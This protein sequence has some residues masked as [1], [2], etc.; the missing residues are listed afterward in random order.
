MAVLETNYS[1]AIKEVESIRPEQTE[2][3]TR[4]SDS[5]KIS[6]VFGH[7]TTSHIAELPREQLPSGNS[8]K[9]PC[10]DSNSIILFTQ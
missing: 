2:L 5:L 7:T 3:E 1:F 6:K 4:T 10:K 8:V 9:L